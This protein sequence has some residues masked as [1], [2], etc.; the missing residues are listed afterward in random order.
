MKL[1]AAK[2]PVL[3]YHKKPVLKQYEK[4]VAGHSQVTEKKTDEI[5]NMAT[6]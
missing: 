2:K 1:A 3:K 6:Y 5:K 4:S